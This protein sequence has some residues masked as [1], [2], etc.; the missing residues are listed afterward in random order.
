MVKI[1]ESTSQIAQVGPRILVKMVDFQKEIFASYE[2]SQISSKTK[3]K[4]PK[5]EQNTHSVQQSDASLA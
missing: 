1:E 3:V 5:L 2:R 4:K